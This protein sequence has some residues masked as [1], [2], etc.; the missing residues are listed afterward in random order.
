MRPRFGF[1][2]EDATES[3]S[4]EE[5]APNPAAQHHKSVIK[6]REDSAES[7]PLFFLAGILFASF[8]TPS[9]F[10]GKEAYFVA[11]SSFASHFSGCSFTVSTQSAQQTRRNFTP[12]TTSIASPPSFSVLTTH[13]ASG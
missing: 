9:R 7:S 10:R 3:R 1:Q 8:A 4:S 2:R 13:V 6:R 5:D 12:M 11:S